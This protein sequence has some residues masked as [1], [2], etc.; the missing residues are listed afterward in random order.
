M[1]DYVRIINHCNRPVSKLQNTFALS[2]LSRTFPTSDVNELL[3]H[4]AQVQMASLNIS[5]NEGTKSKG[6]THSAYTSIHSDNWA[7]LLLFT[8]FKFEVYLGKFDLTTCICLLVFGYVFHRVFRKQA[9]GVHTSFID[10][11]RHLPYSS[12][13]SINLWKA[14]L[15]TWLQDLV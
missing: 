1:R 6:Y 12:Y 4:G 8:N 11:Y 9:Y 3:K 13:A 5:S 2:S 10:I 7:S 15:T 14:L